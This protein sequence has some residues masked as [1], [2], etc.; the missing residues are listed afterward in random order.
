MP[1]DYMV[2]ESLK[3]TKFGDFDPIMLWLN[4]ETFFPFLGDLIDDV[5]YLLSIA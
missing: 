4:L 5:P 2:R 1:L 3:F